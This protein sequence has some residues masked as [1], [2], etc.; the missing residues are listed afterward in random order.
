LHLQNI[1]TSYCIIYSIMQERDPFEKWETQ[2][3]RS[4]STRKKW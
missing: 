3:E 2:H 1:I 4:F